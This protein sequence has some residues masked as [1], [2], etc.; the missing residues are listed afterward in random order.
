MSRFAPRLVQ[1]A[2][3][4]GISVDLGCRGQARPPWATWPCMDLS[5]PSPPDLSSAQGEA[6]DYLPEA[7]GVS[8]KEASRRRGPGTTRSEAPAPGSRRG[9]GTRGPRATG[10][11]VQAP[12]DA[13]S[14]SGSPGRNRGLL[15]GRNTQGPSRGAK[16]GPSGATKCPARLERCCRPSPGAALT[17][18]P[19]PGRSSPEVPFPGAVLSPRLTRRLPPGPAGCGRILPAGAGGSH[20]PGQQAGPDE[21]LRAPGLHLPPLPARPRDVPLL[22]PEGADLRHRAQRPPGPPGP[23]APV[24]SPVLAGTAPGWPRISGA[25]FLGKGGMRSRGK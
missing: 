8:R 21:A 5:D 11:A 15:P 18:G 4:V 23:R 6:T 2:G 10:T 19:S 22:L 20:G 25:G 17:W 13:R 16:A 14:V 24:L 9:A 3:H 12:V 7:L 1:K